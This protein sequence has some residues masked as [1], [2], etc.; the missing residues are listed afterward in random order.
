V[1]QAHIAIKLERL[2]PHTGHGEIGFERH[3]DSV[4]IKRELQELQSR[5][6]V[7]Q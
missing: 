4:A 5:R 2:H 6:A 1:R 7:R 3:V